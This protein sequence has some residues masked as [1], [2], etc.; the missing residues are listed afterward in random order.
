MLTTDQLR[1]RPAAFRSLT[2]LTGDQFDHL[3]QEVAAH[4]DAAEAAR[5]ARPKRRRARGAGRK[6]SRPLADRL[7]MA[8]V[9]LRVYPTY[10][11]LGVLF[12]FNKST[13]CRRLQFMLPLLREITSADLKWPDEHQ[14]KRDLGDILRDFPDLE[15]LVDATEQ[16][17]RRPKS[18]PEQNTQ[19]AYYSGK[20]KKHALKTQ[21]AIAP[22][23][24][25]LEVSASVPGATSDL[26]LLR[27]TKTPARVSGGLMCDAGYQ[28]LA[29]DYPDQLLYQAHRASRGHPLTE[30]Q[31]E[32]NRRLSHYRIKIEHVLA[33]LKVF[34]VLAQVYRHRREA[35][36]GY[37]RLVAALTNRRLG[38]LPLQAS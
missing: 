31:R 23:G 36:N 18:T 17:I 7:L 6:F 26:T 38:F 27:E 28:G 9:W 19:Q 32:E 4:F 37:F 1:P 13:I 29:N 2:G 25:I 14:R 11:V 35:Y 33:Q 3:Y 34:Q 24:R 21:I 20:K 30:T 16:R 10:E 12:G 15:V 5:L 22:D 8:L